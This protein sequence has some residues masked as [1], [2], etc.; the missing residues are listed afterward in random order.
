MRVAKEVGVRLN[1]ELDLLDEKRAY[2][3][4]EN[5]QLK[6]ELQ[7]SQQRRIT[8]ENELGRMRLEVRQNKRRFIPVVY[9]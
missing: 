8:L 5:R 7:C 1:S 9:A 2:H 3:E 4:E 6:E